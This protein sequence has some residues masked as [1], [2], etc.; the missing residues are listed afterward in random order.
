MSKGILDYVYVP[1]SENVADILTKGLNRIKTRCFT[2]TMGLVE[3][4]IKGE[5]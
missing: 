3:T 1:S 4:I 5:C 2:K